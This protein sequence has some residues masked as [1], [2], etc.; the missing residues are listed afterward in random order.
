MM[1]NVRESM[2]VLG[3]DGIHVGTVEKAVRNRIMLAPENGGLGSPAGH[4]HFISGG[5]VAGIE[6][7]RMRLSASAAVAVQFAEAESG[8]QAIHARDL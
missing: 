2:Q 4:R 1:E 7:H 5:R 8:E 6:G 3:A